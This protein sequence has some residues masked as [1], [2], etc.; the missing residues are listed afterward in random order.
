MSYIGSAP[1]RAFT[2]FGRNHDLP[3]F[4]NPQLH[5]PPVKPVFT[6]P[7]QIT[8]P[9]PTGHAALRTCQWLH[10]DAGDLNW[11]GASVAYPGCSWCGTHE[12]IV[13]PYGRPR[14]RVH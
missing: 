4:L 12:K 2:H 7:E 10:G 5:E 13:F 1:T 11:C 6:A 14:L 3:P 9:I 8:T